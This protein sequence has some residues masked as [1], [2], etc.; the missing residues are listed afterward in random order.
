MEI[1]LPFTSVKECIEG[2]IAKEIE[3]PT[4]CCADLEC[5]RITDTAW[6][7]Q[8]T[9]FVISDGRMLSRPVTMWFPLCERHAPLQEVPEST[10][11]ETTDVANRPEG[12]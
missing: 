6:I 2:G 7:F 10:E 8:S 4:V 1:D 11:E 9:T 12:T 3:A 5:V